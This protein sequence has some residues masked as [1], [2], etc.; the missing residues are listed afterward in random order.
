VAPILRRGAKGRLGQPKERQSVKLMILALAAPVALTLAAP[1]FAQ[2]GFGITSNN[3]NA[4]AGFGAINGPGAAPIS[5]QSGF[6]ASPNGQVTT[7]IAPAPVYSN[8]YHAVSPM[9]YRRPNG[10]NGAAPQPAPQQ[11]GP[12]SGG[13]FRG[14]HYMGLGGRPP[15]QAGQSPRPAG[16]SGGGA[17]PQL[18]FGFR[19]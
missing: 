7:M 2:N 14:G 16:N 19:R 17:A 11:A 13:G 5:A 15:M 4:Q 8:P 18:T 3:P 6:S 1:A 12:N 10:P 9:K